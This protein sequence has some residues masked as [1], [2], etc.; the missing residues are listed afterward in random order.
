MTLKEI[1]IKKYRYVCVENCEVNFTGLH[2][3]LFVQVIAISTGDTTLLICIAGKQLISYK[4]AQ[5]TLLFFSLYQ[6]PFLFVLS[7]QLFLVLFPNSSYIGQE[8][9]K[10][11][12]KIG[13]WCK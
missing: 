7:D 10:S 4:V 11:T 3:L 12:L 8:L 13:F 6:Y 2:I 1:L 9:A 5:V